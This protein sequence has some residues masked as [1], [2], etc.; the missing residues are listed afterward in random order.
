MMALLTARRGGGRLWKTLDGKPFRIGS[1][2]HVFSTGV[3]SPRIEIDLEGE[4][5][6]ELQLVRS[7]T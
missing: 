1:E 3:Q 4:R 5:E 7:G 6:E 2:A